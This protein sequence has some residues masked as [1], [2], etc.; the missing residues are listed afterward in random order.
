MG[1][2]SPWLTFTID[3]IGAFGAAG[4]AIVAVIL[5]N[6]ERANSRASEA[7]LREYDERDRRAQAAAVWA[8]VGPED[9]IELNYEGPSGRS[10]WAEVHNT[11]SLP[12]HDVELFV[13]PPE[14]P[15]IVDVIHMAALIGPGQTKRA[16]GDA[17]PE[18]TGTS[19]PAYRLMFKDANGI[20]W[21]RDNYGS[22]WSNT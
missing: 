8:E 6:R 2:P 11:S 7:R 3:T 15:T 5:A 10:W 18:I 12:I 19:E 16:N 17:H 13:S 20:V 14:S 22:L 9:V 21:T 1:D 4:A